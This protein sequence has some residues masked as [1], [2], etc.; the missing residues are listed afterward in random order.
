MEYDLLFF[1]R[2]NRDIILMACRAIDVTK[3]IRV[4]RLVVAQLP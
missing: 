3:Q 2:V 4:I 1:V